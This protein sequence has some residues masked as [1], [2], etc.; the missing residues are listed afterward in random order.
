VIIPA[1]N[2]VRAARVIRVIDGDTIV[3]DADQGL[4]EHIE[5]P[6]RIYGINAPERGDPGGAEATV[7]M[8]G[9][10]AAAGS[11]V[12]VRTYKPTTNG[13][14]DKYGRWLA[15]VFSASDGTDFGV[16]MLAAGHASAYFGGAR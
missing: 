6:L 1:D 14:A 5:I 7:Y 10:V 9:L 16:A 2:H 12:M 15:D 13:G 4:Y 11:Q 3:V 8:I